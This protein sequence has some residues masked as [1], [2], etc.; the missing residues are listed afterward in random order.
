MGTFL[1]LIGLSSI[2][3]LL[4]YL[5][6]FCLLTCAF[7]AYST[8]TGNFGDVTVEIDQYA[9]VVYDM[10]MQIGLT[11]MAGGLHMPGKKDN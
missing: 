4:S 11:Y 9:K 8:N 6:W 3:T 7:W 1:S 10:G 2:A 5:T